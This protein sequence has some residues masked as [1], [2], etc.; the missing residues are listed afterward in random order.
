MTPYFAYKDVNHALFTSVGVTVLIL[1]T[2]GYIKAV[3]T[4]CTRKDAVI[5]SL[6][7]L[8]IGVLA[9]STSYGIVRGFNEIRPVHI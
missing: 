9:A 2:F 5:G 1:L 4:G 7:T 3:V 6:Q 8:F